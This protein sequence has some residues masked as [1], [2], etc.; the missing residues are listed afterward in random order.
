M[1]YGSS[2]LMA[3]TALAGVPPA[4]VGV[5]GDAR[6]RA[7]GVP[8]GGHALLVS[9]RRVADLDLEH[10]DA[11]V[12]RGPG[13]SD[14]FVSGSSHPQAMTSDQAVAGAAADQV[15]ERPPQRLALKVPERHLHAGAGRL[16]AHH[17]QLSLPTAQHAF[18]IEGV[19]TDERRSEVLADDVLHRPQR[20]A[21]EFKRRTGLA[22]AYE[23]LVRLHANQVARPGGERRRRDDEGLLVL[24]LQRVNA[25]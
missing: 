15:V 22:V 8:D 17:E 24:E 19:A 6:L 23:A 12:S 13:L 3:A 2:R 20:V 11:Q 9:F 21:C 1:P 7:G 10:G 18:H 25:D 4:L 5:H 14:E 16:I